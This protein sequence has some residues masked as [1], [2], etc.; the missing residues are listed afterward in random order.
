MASLMSCPKWPLVM[1]LASM[2]PYTS[3]VRL[4]EHMHHV[5]LGNA[6]VLDNLSHYNVNKEKE[7]NHIIF[8]YWF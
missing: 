1:G 8:I 5:V 3:G 2:A 7:P 6:T 4:E